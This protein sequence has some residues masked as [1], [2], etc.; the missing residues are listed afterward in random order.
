VRRRARW[1]PP[2][3][4]PIERVLYPNKLDRGCRRRESKPQ[5]VRKN[6]EETGR[7]RETRTHGDHLPDSANSANHGSL[8]TSL[9]AR[10]DSEKLTV[11]QLEEAL[12]VALEM[13]R[14]EVARRLRDRIRA[15]R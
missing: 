15:L 14:I 2:E 9:D 4:A 7:N 1:V 5:A 6:E 11:A 10:T 12:D 8:A 3:P 13:G